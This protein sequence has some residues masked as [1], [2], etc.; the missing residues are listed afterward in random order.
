MGNSAALSESVARAALQSPNS[1]R[2]LK[3]F[4]VGSCIKWARRCKVR[5]DDYVAWERSILASL[6]R[7]HDEPSIESILGIKRNVMPKLRL[8]DWSE[9]SERL[10]KWVED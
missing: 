8:Y 1:S 10:D 5:F 9:L 7:V 4:E 3:D 2:I 6:D